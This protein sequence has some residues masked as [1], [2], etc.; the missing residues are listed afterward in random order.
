[1]VSFTIAESLAAKMASERG[2]A[3]ATLLKPQEKQKQVETNGYFFCVLIIIIKM[4]IMIIVIIIM[5][6]IMIIG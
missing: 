2:D 6:I 1:M 3:L 5:I 4:T